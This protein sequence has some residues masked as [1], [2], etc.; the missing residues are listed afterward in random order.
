VSAI[1][2]GQQAEVKEEQRCGDSPVNVAGP[3]DLAVDLGEGVRDVVVLVADLDG[4]DGDTVAGSHGEVRERRTYGDESGN[5][6]VET[7]VLNELVSFAGNSGVGIHTT[8]TLHDRPAKTADEMSM[9]MKTTQSVL[10]PSSSANWYSGLS[11][12]T[13]GNDEAV[14][15]AV[16]RSAAVL[17]FLSI[18]TGSIIMMAVDGCVL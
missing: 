14:A 1:E 10:L 2:T 13:V 3:E 5:D 7:L 17:V 11:G 4:V 12:R 9:T 8:G 18:S 16:G 15:V 6:V